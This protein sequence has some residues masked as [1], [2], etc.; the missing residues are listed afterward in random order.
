[1]NCV[2]YLWLLLP[3]HF[4][5]FVD[6]SPSLSLSFHQARNQFICNE[7]TC[8]RIKFRY[9]NCI[10]SYTICWNQSTGNELITYENRT[11]PTISSKF[12]LWKMLPNKVEIHYKSH[13]ISFSG[14]CNRCVCQCVHAVNIVHCIGHYFRLHNISS[15]YIYL[16]CTLCDSNTHIHTHTV[17]DIG[18][19]IRCWCCFALILILTPMLMLQPTLKLLL[20]MRKYEKLHF[21]VQ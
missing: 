13:F 14:D 11:E 3:C 9:F 17:F 19:G 8:Y 15:L 1:M 20:M 21:K 10:L 6:F 18:N 7:C 2:F 5:L 4:L 16:S 12:N